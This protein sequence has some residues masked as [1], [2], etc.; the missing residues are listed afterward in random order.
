VPEGV[1]LS[2]LVVNTIFNSK[3]YHSLEVTKD[4]VNISDAT[5]NGTSEEF[6]TV[7]LVIQVVGYYNPENSTI[8]KL[9]E[10]IIYN[11][12]MDEPFIVTIPMQTSEVLN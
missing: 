8:S 4:T 2:N 9:D 12:E 1:E 6:Y 3:A 7:S 10:P 5:L 11:A